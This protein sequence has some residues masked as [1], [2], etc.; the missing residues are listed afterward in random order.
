MVSDE[1]VEEALALDATSKLIMRKGLAPA[2]GDI[3]G[4]RFNLNLIKSKGVPIQSVHAGNRPDDYRRNTG[5]YDGSA[6]AYHKDVTLENVYFN[7]LRKGREDGHLVL[8][9]SFP[10]LRLTGLL[11]TPRP[12][13]WG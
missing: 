12:I 2:A 7:A 3:V 11:W 5:L 6:M 13:Y 10:L 4:I 8:S 1:V 9:A